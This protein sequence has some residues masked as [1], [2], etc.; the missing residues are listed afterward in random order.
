[1]NKRNI[2]RTVAI[3][4]FILLSIAPISSASISE[5]KNESIE[6]KMLNSDDSGDDIPADWT[7]I[8]SGAITGRVSAKYS[9]GFGEFLDVSFGIPFGL[10]LPSLISRGRV[11]IRSNGDIFWSRN[12][13]SR[14]EGYLYVNGVI[15]NSFTA[16]GFRGLWRITSIQLPVADF[17][18]DSI[19][20]KGYAENV[21]V[22]S[23]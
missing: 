4:F 22:I 3:L 19:E 23:K 12:M 18:V 9:I 2:L 1:M 16:E 8:G 17:Y 6:S 11:H 20:I 14:V 15:C 13:D 7:H 5:V 21:F 10:I